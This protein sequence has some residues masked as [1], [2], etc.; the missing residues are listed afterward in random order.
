MKLSW[1][2]S[3]GPPVFTPTREGFGTKLLKAVCADVLQFAPTGLN[4][5]IDMAIGGS[6]LAGI[7]EPTVGH[8]AERLAT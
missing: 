3:G 2:E 7:S 8:T 5:E 6:D 1:R 4:C